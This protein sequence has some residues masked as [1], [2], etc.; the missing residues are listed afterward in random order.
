MHVHHPQEDYLEH[1]TLAKIRQPIENKQESVENNT[2]RNS[3]LNMNPM[4]YGVTICD[5]YG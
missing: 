4:V 5:S 2:S 1:H 3:T